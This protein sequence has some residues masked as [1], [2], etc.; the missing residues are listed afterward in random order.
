MYTPRLNN[1]RWFGSHTAPATRPDQERQGAS[2]APVVQLHDE[3]DRLFDGLFRG[4]MNPWDFDFMPRRA[5][6]N[7]AESAIMPRLDASS[8]E[9][10]YT[11]TAELPGVQPDNVKIEVRDNALILEG[12]KK[13]ENTEENKDY[14]VSERSYGSFRRVLALPEDAVIDEIKASHKDGVLR[15]SIPRREPDKP[16]SKTIEISRDEEPAPQ[17]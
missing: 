9:K 13:D 6:A 7:G 4:M 3:I 17:E 10:A 14:Y 5:T 8:D 11:V 2:Y 15:I 16:Q 1:R 12:E